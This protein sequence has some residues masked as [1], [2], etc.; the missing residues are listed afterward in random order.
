MTDRTISIKGKK[1]QA[2]YYCTG[3]AGGGTGATIP[4]PTDG[5][6]GGKCTP[7]NYC[8]E[9]SSAPQPCV[10]GTY[11]TR[12]GSNECQD[13]PEGYYCPTGAS[14]PIECANGYCPKKSVAP[15]LCSSGTYGSA[16]LTKLVSQ[17]DC[18][19]C[20]NT[21]WCTNGLIQGTCAR[22]YYC[23]FGAVAEQDSTKI[24]PAGHYCP[25]GTELPIRCPKGF[26]YGSTG[27]Y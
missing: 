21:K 5:V 26:Y 2:G 9:G 3:G 22:G 20:P 8:P 25:L 15:T 11:E 13:C 7:G 12:D 23:D 24:C 27:A 14:T 1:C 16:T 18:P 4:N 6:T 19:L 17:D 10:A